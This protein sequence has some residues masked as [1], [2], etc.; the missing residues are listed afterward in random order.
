MKVMNHSEVMKRL[1]VWIFAYQK[2]VDVLRQL[3]DKQ[4]KTR[5]L[6]N[7]VHGNGD[8]I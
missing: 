4:K 7:T 8:G 6:E 5:K 3:R 2:V 1:D